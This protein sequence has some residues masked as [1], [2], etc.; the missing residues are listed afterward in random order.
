MDKT[1]DMVALVHRLILAVALGLAIVGLSIHRPSGLYDEAETEIN[2]LQT[3]IAAVTDQVNSVFRKIYAQSELNSSTLAWL[4]GRR[5]LQKQLRIEVVPAGNL[6]VPDAGID[7]LVT[8]DSQVKWA[9]RIYRVDD[10]PFYLCSVQRPQLFQAY[11][12]LFGSSPPPQ[13]EQITV[14][15]RRA[16][17]DVNATV[18]CDLQLSYSVQSGSLSGTRSVL[19]DVP[20]TAV[21]IDELAPP[22][23]HW[24]EMDLA[25]TLKENGLGDFEDT[26]SVLLPSVEQFWNEIGNR[27]PGAALAWLDTLKEEDLEKSKE[28]V[29]ILGESLSGSLTIMLTC[30]IEL[31]LIVYLAAL[32]RQIRAQLPGHTAEVA[33][34]QFFGLMI[35]TLGQGVVCFTLLFPLAAAAWSLFRI[36]PP[37]APEWPGA[38]WQVSLTSRSIL[39]ALLA[40]VEAVIF[41]EIRSIL[42]ALRHPPAPVEPAVLPSGRTEV[43]AA[44]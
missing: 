2:S 10:G 27:P 44:S 25:D 36:F 22:G 6:Q 21:A 32:L 16:Q 14:F 7:P 41:L 8:L 23:P 35:S 13:F 26:A 4:G 31:C 5:S 38:P 3:A 40:A 12:K 15:L 43:H 19:L 11:G 24:V 9:D 17:A 18:R 34:S 37:F 30:V 33:E 39:I 20:T 28:K 29:D 1:L 42:A